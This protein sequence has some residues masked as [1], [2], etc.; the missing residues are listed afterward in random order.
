MHNTINIRE[1]LVW[2][3]GSDRRITLFEGAYPLSDG[4]S[5]NSYLLTDEKKVLFDTVDKEIAGLF[6]ENLEYALNGNKLDY[7]IVQHVEPDHSATLKELILRYP[8]VKIICSKQAVNMIRQF[9]GIEREMQVV[10]EG[11]TVCTG[12]HELTFINAP[13]VHWP[14]VIM[15]YDK[16]DKILFSAD[17]FGSFGAFNGGITDSANDFCFADYLSEA[18]RYYA[19]IVGKYGPQV[20]AV[21]KKAAAIEIETICPLHGVIWQSHIKEIVDVYG[22]WA[23]Y[24]PEKEG[25]V[26]LYGSIYGNSANS[27]D[28]L[29]NKLADKGVCLR[30]MDMSM[31]HPSY[32][33]AAVFEYSS[34]VIVSPTVD[35]GIFGPID[36]MLN[37]FVSHNIS[38]RKVAVIDNGT[39]APMAGKLIKEK[40]SSCKDLTI[41]EESFSIKSSLTNVQAEGELEKLAEALK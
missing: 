6:F 13:M 5:Y 29:A 3:G 25:V 18:R 17:A 8:D 37:S 31:K 40:L 16:T 10:K 4:M 2:L 38:N 23:A 11:D 33:L 1:D 21:L 22:K 19:N 28:I 27:A 14:E 32:A 30:V 35:A 41:L 26:I 34:F 36:N 9:Y 7:V 12:K 20:S 15:T 24:E 39:W